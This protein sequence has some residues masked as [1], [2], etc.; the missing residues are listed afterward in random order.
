MWL[1]GMFC[2][3]YPLAVSSPHSSFPMEG[4]SGK[5][6]QELWICSGRT[7]LVATFSATSGAAAELPLSSKVQ[8]LP[9]NGSALLN[10]PDRLQRTTL[11]LFESQR[12][13]LV[14]NKM[15]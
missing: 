3:Q 7:V 1:S 5:G 15:N 6:K 4:R 12:L 14:F 9:S 10:R 8:N 11:I 2:S 13:V